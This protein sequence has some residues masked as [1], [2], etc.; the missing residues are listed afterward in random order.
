MRSLS[1]SSDRMKDLILHSQTSVVS[2][3]S[4]IIRRLSERTGNRILARTRVTYQRRLPLYLPMNYGYTTLAGCGATTETGEGQVV[5]ITRRVL[6]AATLCTTAAERKCST[7]TVTKNETGN[8]HGDASG[9]G[10]S[11][12]EVLRRR[13]ARPTLGRCSPGCASAGS[14]RHSSPRCGRGG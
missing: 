8:R 6:R 10:M 12:P 11:G 9:A 5:F 13:A 4:R 14:S 3:V 7:S 1:N 2:V